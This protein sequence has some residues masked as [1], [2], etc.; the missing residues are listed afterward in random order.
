VCSRNSPHCEV[1]VDDLQVC[2]GLC[3]R[4]AVGEG[5]RE[6]KDDSRCSFEGR[7]RGWWSM[8]LVSG[9]RERVEDELVESR[10]FG[11][12]GDSKEWY[13][14]RC[15]A[16]AVKACPLATHVTTRLLVK[17]NTE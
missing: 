4:E 6:G 15:H 8:M 11:R 16:D 12:A 13:P 7:H 2:G 5:S 10:S 14:Y 17:L 9:V 3:G 1:T